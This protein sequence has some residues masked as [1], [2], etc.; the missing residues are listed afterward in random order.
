MTARAEAPPW[1]REP[2]PWI[3][4]AGPAA[5]VVA[6]IATAVV[7]WRTS[8]GLVA[9]AYYKQGL[10][11]NRVLEREARARDL[12]I[13]ATVQFSESRVRVRVILRTQGEAPAALRLVLLHPTRAGEDQVIPLQRV[14]TGIYEGDMGIPRGAMLGIRLED[15]AGGWRLD[16]RWP[17]EDSSV[18]LGA[19]P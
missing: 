18:A 16:G 3:V 17:T 15:A 6:G 11:I 14:D 19:F 4:M 5:V 2:W 9:D 7:A 13:S 12:G 1:Y 8:D 10:A